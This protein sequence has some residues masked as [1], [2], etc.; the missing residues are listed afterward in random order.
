MPVATL[1]PMNIREPSATLACGTPLTFKS[2]TQLSRTIVFQWAP[3]HCG[4]QR[5][6]NADL[7]SL[8]HKNR[9]ADLILH[10]RWDL[11][12]IA[13][14]VTPAQ[15]FGPWAKESVL[16]SIV[17]DLDSPRAFY[18]GSSFRQTLSFLT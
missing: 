18:Q 12:Y 4:I 2:A 6:L 13:Y 3:G 15:Q 1:K 5:N 14:C 10:S 17:P 9:A 7:L 8:T 16:Y 11:T